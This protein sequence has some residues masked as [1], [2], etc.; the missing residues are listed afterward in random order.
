[1]LEI[2]RVDILDG[3]TLDIELN[4]GHII[5]LDL[6]FLPSISH[7]YDHLKNLALIPRPHTDGRRICWEDGT[8]I[9]L[10]QIFEWLILQ[11]NNREGQGV[12]S[13]GR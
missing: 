5:L 11:P 1:M 3:Q 6:H 4:N 7:G 2:A 13:G 10:A 9:D 12:R 8:Q